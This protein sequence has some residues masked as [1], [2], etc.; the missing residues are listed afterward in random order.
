VLIGVSARELSAHRQEGNFSCT[1]MRVAHAWSGVFIKCSHKR[2]N[3]P[4][5]QLIAV[6]VLSACLPGSG[7]LSDKSNLDAHWE[8]TWDHASTRRK[9][10]GDI[11]TPGLR[12]LRVLREPQGYERSDVVELQVSVISS[13]LPPPHPA[14]C[15]VAPD[16]TRCGTAACAGRAL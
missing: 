4:V 5:V 10:Q 12:E 2:E 8:R 1:S 7:E 13:T 9:L 14:S 15:G 3:G 16:G 11:G 6:L